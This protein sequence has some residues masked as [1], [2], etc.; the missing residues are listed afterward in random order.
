M[1]VVHKVYKY[2]ENLML[3]RV[4]G[5]LLFGASLL[6]ACDASKTSVSVSP[7]LATHYT[8]S[9]SV[10]QTSSYCGGARPPQELITRL[11]TPTPYPGKTF[12]IRAG[13][14]NDVKIKV[15]TSFTTDKDGNFSINLSA[16]TYAILLKEQVTEMNAADY[17]TKTQ[18][19]DIN[20]LAEW[21]QKPYYLLEVKQNIASLD[22]VF[23]HRC[24]ITHD[25]IPCIRYSGPKPP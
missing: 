22:F 6:S 7:K 19:V 12:Y 5:A 18:A 2:F 4:C 9:G 8:I 17:E 16:G 1:T 3:F 15:L 23:H 14:V 20:C 25:D 10:K 11:A 21:W 13:R 24:F